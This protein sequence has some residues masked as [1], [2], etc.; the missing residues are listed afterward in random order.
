MTENV[1]RYSVVS[2]AIL[3]VDVVRICKSNETSVD[4]LWQRVLRGISA[5]S[6]QGQII[7]VAITAANWLLAYSHI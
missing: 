1:V 3:Y 7:K 5:T 2:S 4:Q 6:S